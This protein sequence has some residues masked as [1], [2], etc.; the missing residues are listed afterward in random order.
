M[1]FPSLL[2][3]NVL[4]DTPVSICTFYPDAKKPSIPSVAVAAGSYVFIYRNLRP[5]YKFSLPTMPVS[6]KESDIWVG[7]SHE[8]I[9]IADAKA[10]LAAVRDGGVALSSVSQDL[11]ATENEAAAQTLV[12]HQRDTPLVRPS[13]CT[14]M[15]VLKREKE[16]DDAVSMVRAATHAAACTSSRAQIAAAAVAHLD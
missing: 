1:W 9:S 13:V 16:D 2:S 4:L 7:L 3:E 14:C 15:E 11:I 8:N 10:K 5:Y 12:E 6:P